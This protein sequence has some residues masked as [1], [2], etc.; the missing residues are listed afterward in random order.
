MS[1]AEKSTPTVLLVSPLTFSYHETICDAL[2]QIGFDPIWWNDKAS[3][4]TIYKLALRL[5]PR[6]TRIVTEQHFLKQIDSMPADS[7][8][9]VLLI[10]AE[11]M[12]ARA[13]RHLRARHPR[14]SFGLY[15]WD[16]K[17]NLNG[18]DKL[19]PLV[20]A[21][22]SF[23]PVDAREN[24]WNY[25]PLFA[26][27]VAMSAS[28][29]EPKMFEWSFIGTIHSDRHRVIN[30]LRKATDDSANCFVFVYFQS[31]MVLKL[32]KLIDWTLW[33]APK[34]TLST[35]PMSA[36]D[37][38]RIT[39]RSKTVL[40]VEH[41]CQRGLTMRTIETLLAGNKLLTTNKYLV[42]CDL[43]HVSRAQIIDRK[44]PR[45]DQA[46]LSQAV[47]PIPQ[48]LQDRYSCEAW[49]KELIDIQS[50]RVRK[51]EEEQRDRLNRAAF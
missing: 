25:R 31:P 36:D 4:S 38:G 29:Q 6:L 15:L 20:D 32:R 11:G 16:G 12:T 49:A 40:D 18:I 13:V 21:V 41:P 10:K 27:K 35:M 26:R 5:L 34:G 1:E 28:G 33:A 22:S 47:K 14:A 3:T 8:D 51:A 19:A 44:A 9:H 24:G 17:E 39:S 7:V 46:F 2:R 30:R 42:D 48:E 37:V 50:R 43:Y 23:D 45:I